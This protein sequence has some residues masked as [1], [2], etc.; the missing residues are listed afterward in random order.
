[1]SIVVRFT[2]ICPH[3]PRAGQRGSRVVLIQAGNGAFINGKRIPPHVPTLMIKPADIVRMEGGMRLDGYPH[4]LEPTGDL[5]I[6]R[7][8]GVQLNLEETL[9][10][11]LE[12]DE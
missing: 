12:W 7:L 5:A 11:G 4:G 10:S 1:M 2:G 9:G 8:C 6:W 3:V